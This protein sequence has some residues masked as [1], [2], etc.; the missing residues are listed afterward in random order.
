M[1]EG[2]ER[3][4]CGLS[5]MLTYIDRCVLCLLMTGCILPCMIQKKC[6]NKNIEMED[7]Q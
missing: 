3:L 4:L 5:N 6:A 7:A 1:K 2:I